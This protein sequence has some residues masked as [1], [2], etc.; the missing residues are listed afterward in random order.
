MTNTTLRS[1]KAA[2]CNDSLYTDDHD[3]ERHAGSMR[4]VAEQIH[5]QVDEIAG[6]YEELLT[7]LKAQASVPDYLPVLV[8]KK[9]R[10]IYRGH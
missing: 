8:S 9:V 5:C 3:R 10:E 6:L 4:A 1:D 2:L 7:E